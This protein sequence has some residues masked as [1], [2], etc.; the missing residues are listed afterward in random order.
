MGSCPD[1]HKSHLLLPRTLSGPIWRIPLGLH[2]Y[3][4]THARLQMRSHS[5][6]DGLHIGT[7][8]CRTSVLL[9]LSRKRHY[10]R[11]KDVAISAHWGSSYQTLFRWHLITAVHC[12]KWIGARSNHLLIKVTGSNI[13]QIWPIWRSS[14]RMENSSNARLGLAELCSTY[15]QGDRVVSGSHYALFVQSTIA[16][17][18]YQQAIAT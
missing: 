10:R 18:A 8:T 5:G 9:P 13:A 6:Q 2:V 11:I 4:R 14:T 3:V 17:A 12:G 16:A 7:E 15:D 1:L